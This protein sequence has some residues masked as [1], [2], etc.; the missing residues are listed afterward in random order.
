MT[1]RNPFSNIL[2]RKKV[3]SPQ[4]AADGAA[5]EATIP[6]VNSRVNTLSIYTTET[7]IANEMPRD[8]N[9]FAIGNGWLAV[10]SAMG[11]LNDCVPGAFVPIKATLVG[12]LAIMDHVEVHSHLISVLDLCLIGEP[13]SY[14]G[15]R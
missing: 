10:K 5:P 11:I 9:S 2:R 6:K 12:V 7:I 4:T 15:P 8:S 3:R 13:E 14:W 1:S